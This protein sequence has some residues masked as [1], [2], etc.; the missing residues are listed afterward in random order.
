[1]LFEETVAVYSVN[2]TEHIYCGQN[3]GCFIVNARGTFCNRC[4]L[5]RY[6]FVIFFILAI[7]LPGTVWKAVN[8]NTV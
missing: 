3:T 5:K 7:V 8:R 1:M 2:Y 4:V 6:V